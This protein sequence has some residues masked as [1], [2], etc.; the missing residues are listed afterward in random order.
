MPPGVILGDVE[1]PLQAVA[2]GRQQDQVVREGRGAD[3]DADEA[4][5]AA[6]AELGQQPVQVNGKDAGTECINVNKVNK[7]VE[8]KGLTLSLFAF[9][10]CISICI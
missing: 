10:F 4:A 1:H 8:M 3:E 9:A 5:T 2:G 7:S 6:V